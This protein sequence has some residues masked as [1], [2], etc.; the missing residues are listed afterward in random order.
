MRRIIVKSIVLCVLALGFSALL[1]AQA[2]TTL[3]AEAVISA[4]RPDG[5]ISG[6]ATLVEKVSR[7]GIKEVEVRIEVQGLKDGRHAVHIHEVGVCSPC[8]DARGHFD[9]GPNSNS[10]PDGNHPY[11][12]G[13]LINIEVKNGRGLLE[14]VTTR[15][16]LSPGPL[17][18]FDQ[19]GSAV[20]IHDNEDTYCPDGV[21]KGCAGGSRAA[22]G[23]IQP[24][25]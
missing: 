17:S 15:V 5:N 11:H 16:S 12:M 3:K 14:T 19:D 10:N 20:I 2:S 9:P 8:G 24:T 18:S 23:I 25:R 13:D 6:K 22:C 7:E 1:N 21:T 4:C